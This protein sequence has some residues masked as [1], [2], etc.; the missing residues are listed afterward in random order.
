MASLTQTALIKLLTQNDIKPYR[1][2]GQNFLIDP[3]FLKT[4][5]RLAQLTRDDYVLEIGVG[6]GLLTDYLAQ[7][8]KYVWAVEIDRRLI[9]L[10]RRVMADRPNVQLIH[11]NILDNRR[12]RLNPQIEA[13]LMQILSPGKDTVS[14]KV[15]ANLPYARATEIIR[16]LLE[17]PLPIKS[18]TVLVQKELVQKLKAE[19]RTSAYHFISVLAQNLADVR[20]LRQ[21]PPHIFWPRP[22]VDSTLISII[23]QPDT[24]A[25]ETYAV[26]KDILGR[27]FQ[28]RRKKILHALKELCPSYMEEQ[29]NNLLREI[30]L[31]PGLRPSEITPQQYR[32]L[33]FKLKELS[34]FC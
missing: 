22:K 24:L 16:S 23:P 4:I 29:W 25:P 15:V 33:A 9:K 6:P 20:I 1:A 10:F 21:A 27:F 3:N 18:I 19:P 12:L 2:L 30:S 7:T 32:A 26:L 28:H 8:A 17:S 11:D 31:S 34:L 5:P 13:A 14:F